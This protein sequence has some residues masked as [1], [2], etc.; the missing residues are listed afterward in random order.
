[1]KNS[2]FARFARAFFLSSDILKTFSFFLR[3]EIRF[4]GRRQHIGW[5]NKCSIF[6]SY[7]PSTGS[8]L[9]NSRTV[10]THFSIVMTLNNWKMIAERRSYIFRWRSR[11][12]R[13]RVCLSSLLR[14]WRITA[15]YFEINLSLV[16]RLSQIEECG[17]LL[18]V[19]LASVF[20]KVLAATSTRKH[21]LSSGLS[22]THAWVSYLISGGPFKN[23]KN[24]LS[25]Y[26]EELGMLLKFAKERALS[27][28]DIRIIIESLGCENGT[29]K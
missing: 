22:F 14:S 15:V 23:L 10:R 3:R 29:T 11:F 9:I 26:C 5:D 13:R 28:L 1:M 8:K 4:C 2:I 24:T 17:I 6:S 25:G 20:R 16:V 19:F 27:L 7:V 18:Q 12:R 21:G